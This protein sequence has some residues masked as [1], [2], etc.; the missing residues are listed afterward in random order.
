M[1]ESDRV[2]VLGHRGCMGKLPENSLLAFKKAVEAGADGVELDVWLT[3]DGKVVVMHDETIDRTSDMSG[4][5]KDMTLEEL[6][7][8][9]IGL[10]ERIPTLEEVFEALPDDALIN[11]ELKDRDAVE[12]VARIVKENNPERVLISSF[13][14]EALRGYR[15]FD[16]ETRMGLLIE[17][18]DVLPMVPKLKEELNLW[19]VNVPIEAIPVLG[20]EKTVQALGWARSLGLKVVLWT[21]NDELF[22]KDDNLLKLKG[23]FEVVIANDVERMLSYLKNAGLR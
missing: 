13:D 4:R 10:G 2:I 19:S 11:V 15:R 14:V 12:E 5:Q 16:K 8:A 18:E 7:K 20:F 17:S 9:D 1:W 3:K 23:L 21:E 6:K 22:Y